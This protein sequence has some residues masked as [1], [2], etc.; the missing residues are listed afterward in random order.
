M[1]TLLYKGQL[2]R[3]LIVNSENLSNINS[4]VY[5]NLEKSIYKYDEENDVILIEYGDV[6]FVKRKYRIVDDNNYIVAKFSFSAYYFKPE[7]NK[8][9]LANIVELTENT[10]N[11]NFYGFCS[12]I[13]QFNN[14]NSKMINNEL[15]YSFDNSSFDKEKY[16]SANITIN[17]KI[18]IKLEINSLISVN[19]VDKILSESNDVLL[20]CSINVSEYK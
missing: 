14:D 5:Q 6:K 2:K 8:P 13:I 3:D 7:Y 11:L 17:N 10:I 15:T 18:N 9:L 19:I 4:I 16:Y 12:G 20:I 1:N